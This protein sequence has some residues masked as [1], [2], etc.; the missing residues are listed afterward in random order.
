MSERAPTP[1]LTSHGATGKALGRRRGE[2]ALGGAVFV[3]LGLSLLQVASA[4]TP[5]ASPAFD[6]APSS[7]TPA[8]SGQP[9]PAELRDYPYCEVIPDTVADDTTTEHVFNTL[10]YGPCIPKQFAEV[11]EQDIIDAY[12]EAYGADATSATVNGPRHWVLDT[13]TSTGGV[14]ASG[15]ELTVD[16][17]KFGLVGQLQTPVGQPTIGTDPYVVNTVQRNTIYLFKAGRQVFELTD[18]SG[19]VYVMQSYSQ[20]VEP[21]LSLRTLADIGPDLQL[22]EGWSYAAR[23]LDEDLTLTASGSTQIVNDYYKNT[24][25]IDPSAD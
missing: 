15:D 6:A 20:Q 22:P 16:G 17:I 11:T 12:N 3:S 7:A 5:S 21:S 18:P 9:Q 23:T 25:Q 4:A 24:Y 8:G 13:L 19:N 10:P 2:T 14:T 1:G